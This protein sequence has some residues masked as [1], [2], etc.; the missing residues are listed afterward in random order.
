MYHGILILFP[1]ERERDR[2][3][4]EERRRE[5]LRC[6]S[7][8]SEK[9]DDSVLNAQG[10]PSFPSRGSARG[11]RR[12]GCRLREKSQPLTMCHRMQKS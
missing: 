12:A 4:K 5:K 11:S 1:R 9:Q 10:L 8:Q 2:G 7:E 6:P 3:R